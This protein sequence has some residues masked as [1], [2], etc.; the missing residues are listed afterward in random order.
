MAILAK[1]TSLAEIASMN[2]CEKDDFFHDSLSIVLTPD[3]AQINERIKSLDSRIA[4]FEK[5]NG[6]SSSLMEEKVESGE[7]EENVS[8]CSWLILLR[9]KDHLAKQLE[10]QS[11]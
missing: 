1:S 9:K 7:I 5:E 10:A 6:L 11:K 2:D 4:E 3:Q 8:I